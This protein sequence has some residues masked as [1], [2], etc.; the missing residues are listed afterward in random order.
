MPNESCPLVS[1]SSSLANL[2][3]F[4]W[5]KS[6]LWCL[7][8]LLDPFR[9]FQYTWMDLKKMGLVPN[10]SRIPS[11]FK[12]ISSIPNLPSLITSSRSNNIS[13]TLSLFSLIGK[14]VDKIDEVTHIRLR[15][16]YYWIAGL[17]SS[18]S[19]IFGRAFYT[20]D[21]SSGNR[22]IYFSHWIPIPNDRMVLTPC[23]GC[24][25]HC[26]DDNEGPLALK[27]VGGKLIHRSCLSFLP[28]YRCLNLYQMTAHI[29]LSQQLINLK[30]SPFI[31]CSYF[32][33]LLEFSE[34]YI[35]EQ[36]L[37][38][39][40]SFLRQ[41]DDSSTHV[42][43]DLTPPPSPAFALSSNT[44][45]H[46]VGNVPD[47][48]P[49]NSHLKCVWVQTLDDYIL[50][51]GVFSC[52]IVSPYKDIAELTFI[53]YVL[54]SFPSESVVEFSSLLQ[55]RPSYHNW[56]NVSP[57]KRP[58]LKNNF[59]WLCIFELI[60][61]KRIS[62]GFNELIE[63]AP[64]PPYL[65]RALDFIKDT[66]HSAL[67]RLVPLMDEVFPPFLKTMGHFTGLDE[68][69]TQDPV[70]YWRSITDIKNFF[71]LLGLSRFTML[72]TSFHAVDWALSFDTF[73]QSIYPRLMVSNAAT[74]FQ[75]RLKLWFDE[76]PIMYRLCQRFPGLYA[77]DSLCPNCGIFMET[78]EHLFICSSSSL[79]ASDSNPKPLQHKDITVDLIQRF[80]IKLATKVSY[81]P[82]CKRTYE[83]LLSA[84]RSLDSIGLPSLL[85]N[86]GIS[87]F[88]ASWFLRGFIPCDLPTFLM[89]YSGLKYRSVSSIISRTFLKLQREI[90]HNLW[91]PRCKIKVQHDLAKGIRG[92][93]EIT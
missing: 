9:R 59:L 56:M 45:F 2:E 19:L 21:D 12:E 53:I 46:I 27:S 82:E 79:D 31:L 48:D 37:V 10:T 71:S 69:L 67:S 51:S 28:S 90:Y 93:P 76:L 68:L 72:Q 32:R 15:N 91:R 58:R 49:S 64:T 25:L 92:V 60:K 88:S 77:D 18:N 34:M 3:T 29:D 16:K 70:A 80:I 7:S 81:S 47:G 63:N 55:L 86:S 44:Q 20:F 43:S 42:S 4:S 83:E 35:L 54:N 40:T 1:I 84:L 8:Q 65:A 62:C 24:S 5:L 66:A 50:E 30:L 78:L 73:Q 13:I 22:V 61:S 36:F 41:S 14:F 33:F 74:F 87:S 17:D 38:M 39:D 6:A 11:W 57:A 75:F 26:L 52:P 23:P 89:R 85:S